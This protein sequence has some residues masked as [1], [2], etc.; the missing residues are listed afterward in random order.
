MKRFF[1][2]IFY[3]VYSFFDSFEQDTWS[4]WK[5]LVIIGGAQMLL[6]VEI[7]NWFQLIFKKEDIY[8]E[9]PY[10]IVVPAGVVLA[11]IDYNFFLKKENW[12]K[13]Q[14]DFKKLTKSESQLIGW[15]VFLIL[16]AVVA[17]LCFSFYQMSLV[18]WS[19]YNE[20]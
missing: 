20:K 6:L 16:T 2:L 15:L 7:I 5:A 9:N 11:F 18:D 13:Y 1:Y 14:D 12:K 8:V 3:K 4:D 17:S 10:Y 19:H